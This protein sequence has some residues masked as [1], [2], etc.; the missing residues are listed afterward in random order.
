MST[1][2]MKSVAVTVGICAVFDFGLSYY[3]THSMLGAIV[4]IVLGRGSTAFYL[5]LCSQD[6]P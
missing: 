6:L 4:G 3:H 2:K 1:S 5:W